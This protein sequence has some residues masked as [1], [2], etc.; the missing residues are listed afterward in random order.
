MPRPPLLSCLFGALFAGQALAAACTLRKID[1]LPLT[2]ENGDT[3]LGQAA[4]LEVRFRNEVQDRPVSVFPES[5][6]TVRRLHAELECEVTAGG[7]WGRDG[8]WTS[9]DGATLVTT[10]SSGS[11]E[12]LVFHDTRSCAKVGE[13]DVSGAR[14]R[15][16][17]RTLV[18]SPSTAPRRPTRVPLDADCRP[19]AATRPAR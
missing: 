10:E 12:G 14:W 7:A 17:G 6:M 13:I 18:I 8:V 2:V 19:L 3:Y 1:V 16:A 11:H 5:P 9:T 15:I 4:G